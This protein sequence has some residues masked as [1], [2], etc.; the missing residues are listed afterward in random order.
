MAFSKPRRL[1]LAT[2][3]GGKSQVYTAPRYWHAGSDGATFAQIRYR[4]ITGTI[5]QNLED[6]KLVENRYEIKN[7][8]ADLGY[9][10]PENDAL[11]R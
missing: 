2:R 9:E 7:R 6:V 11:A 1:W 3:N 4:T 8:L 10:W 5:G